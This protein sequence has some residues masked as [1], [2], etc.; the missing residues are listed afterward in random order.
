MIKI[1]E[2]RELIAPN[3]I[4]TKT[5]YKYYFLGVLFKTTECTIKIVS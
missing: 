3:N 1:V 4:Y 5:I 2:T